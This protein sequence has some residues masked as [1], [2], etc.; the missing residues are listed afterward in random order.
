MAEKNREYYDSCMCDFVDVC[1]HEKPLMIVSS[2]KSTLAYEIV[3]M[4]ADRASLFVHHAML[5]CEDGKMHEHVFVASRLPD[6]FRDRAREALDLV[7]QHKESED[8]TRPNFQYMMGEL[9]GHPIDEILDFV[10]SAIS[11]ECPCDCCGGPFVDEKL[12]DTSPEPAGY[13]YVDHKVDLLA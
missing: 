11:R 8:F 10:A 2:G 3:T 1:D 4:M 6:D 12:F 9:L 7:F 13:T 5:R